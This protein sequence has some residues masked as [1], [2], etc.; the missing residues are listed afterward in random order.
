MYEWYIYKS[1]GELLDSLLSANN[2]HLST[3]PPSI[4]ETHARYTSLKNDEYG[5]FGRL[6]N[7]QHEWLFKGYKYIC[8]NFLIKFC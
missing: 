2:E 5:A 3:Y 6:G 1:H 7:Q 8:M 4:S